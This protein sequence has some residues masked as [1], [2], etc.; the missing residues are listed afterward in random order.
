MDLFQTIEKRR[1]VRKFSSAKVP[2]AVIED[3]LQM[4]ILAPNSSNI[5]PWD[6]HWLRE[7][8]KEQAAI[9]CLNQVP[10]RTS[11][12]LIVIESNVTKWKR[13]STPLLEYALRHNL[14]KGM[15]SY[16]QKVLPFVYMTDPIGFIA[17][18]K[19]LFFSFSGLFRP[20]PRR[21]MTQRDHDE[22]ALK[23]AAFAG[24]YFSLAITAN[25]YSSCVME[26]FDEKRLRRLLK[27]DR[28]S[29]IAMVIAV[30]VE[31]EDHILTP[32]IRLPL[33]TVV[34]RDFD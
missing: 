1:S 17:A 32:R 13:A 15:I 26:G 14:S 34:H 29:R 12:D 4:A 30:G 18:C 9:C 31:A 27:L 33:S 11:S 5:Q 8:M 16:H 19:W 22:V 3:T 10:A 24:A 2:E 23:S 21:P 20:V 28:R 25:G 6:F 7:G